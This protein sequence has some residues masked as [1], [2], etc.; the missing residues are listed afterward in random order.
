MTR[1]RPPSRRTVNQQ[2]LDRSIE[3]FSREYR[4][5]EA[6]LSY[7]RRADSQIVRVE[8][9]ERQDR[10]LVHVVL[11]ERLG[12]MFDIDLEVLCMATE[13]DR[14]EPR[15]LDDLQRSLETARVD[16][17]IAV[18]ASADPNVERLTRKRPGGTAVL[19]INAASLDGAPD[20]GTA[21]ARMLVTVDHFNVTVPIADPTAFFGRE[22][23]IEEARKCLGAGQHL[24]IF[25]LRKAG[26]SSLLN[27]IQR[28]AVGDRW[29]VARIDLNGY[30]GRASRAIEDLLRRLHGS[31][32]SL[33]CKPG[34]L[35]SIGPTVSILQRYW[36]DDLTMLLDASGDRADVLI[37][38]DE[39]D[40]ILPGR[41]VAAGGDDADRSLLVAAFSQ[42]RSIAQQRQA[43]ARSYPVVLSAGVDPHIFEAPTTGGADNPLY[44]FSR[45]SFL[46][47]LD[48]EALAQMV[49]TL[50]KRTGM[51]FRDHRLID[52]LRDEY[53][54]H[55]LLT[56]QACSWLHEHRPRGEVP[57]VATVEALHEAFSASGTGTAS[58]HAHDTLEAFS[59]WYPDEAML[60][61]RLIAGEDVATTS[62][63]HA[64]DYG[65]VDSEGRIRIRAL[66]RSGP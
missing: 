28:V 27:Q 57:Y 2:V 55:P 20:L 35:R 16:D 1:S 45:V 62:M 65:L 49:R 5:G 29:A 64:V 53:G 10:W 19:P 41:L 4:Y 26:K 33:G 56:R 48:R 52:E 25:G 8:K 66:T 6:L 14:V 13:Y 34:R 59:S 12:E 31:L 43:E 7:F 63:R 38:I 15:V 21:L 46:E 30:G 3:Q 9:R 24:G 11:P 47:P 60:V 36:L 22:H 23:D 61:Y 44:Q 18:L 40:I 32:T 42:L 58:R 51:R 50:G 54:G 39:I 17:E 37:I